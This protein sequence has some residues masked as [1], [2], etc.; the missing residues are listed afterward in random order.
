[1][2]RD[3]NDTSLLGRQQTGYDSYC[4]HCLSRSRS[5]PPTTIVPPQRPGR[6]GIRCT[7]SVLDGQSLRC[8]H[9]SPGL[10]QM[11]QLQSHVATW[12]MC[13]SNGSSGLSA[14]NPVAWCIRRFGSH[15]VRAQ[16]ANIALRCIA[17]VLMLAFDLLRDHVV[18]S[19]ALTNDTYGNSFA[20][21]ANEAR[22]L[23]THLICNFRA[24]WRHRQQQRRR[25]DFA[26]A[27]RL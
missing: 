27:S 5:D 1:M 6:L 23:H 16:A 12:S 18:V 15:P 10:L 7:V 20:R 11:D 19:L 24:V 25:E 9:R 8:T 22:R 3:Q 14:D 2:L 4:C 26:F 21:S 17:I 13:T